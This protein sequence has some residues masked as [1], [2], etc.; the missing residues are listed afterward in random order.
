M[1][2][3]SIKDNRRDFDRLQKELAKLAHADISLGVQGSE[4]S[5]MHGTSNATV[6]DIAAFHEFGLGV[7]QRSFLRGWADEDKDRIAKVMQ[8]VL[9][10][11]TKGK[12]S[13]EQGLNQAG[14]IFV[15]WIQLRISNRIPPPLAS[16]TIARKKS[17][18]PL[19]DT[20]QLRSSITYRVS[21]GE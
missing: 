18:V 9:K 12:M 8:N 14:A 19:I 20:G 11:V 13:A 16:S 3:V 4:A 10:V 1:G 15:G 6:A 5:Q 7:P 17:D 2:V 21:F